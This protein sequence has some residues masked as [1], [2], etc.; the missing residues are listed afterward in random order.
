MNRENQGWKPEI[1]DLTENQLGIR[2]ACMGA[3][4]GNA[5][6]LELIKRSGIFDEEF[7]RR[8]YNDV[9][10]SGIDP[11]LHYIQF[12]FSERRLPSEKIDIRFLDKFYERGTPSIPEMVSSLASLSAYDQGQS[13]HNL[14]EGGKFRIP[15]I[16]CLI[17]GDANIRY[18]D[19]VTLVSVKDHN[20]F[21]LFTSGPDEEVP[22]EYG[23]YLD[24]YGIKYI[25]FNGEIR[26]YISGFN[27]RGRWPREMLARFAIPY[28]F[29]KMGYDYLIII[30]YDILCIRPYVLDDILELDGVVN[31]VKIHLNT[32]WF[33]PEMRAYLKNRWNFPP[34][35]FD[36]YSFGGGFLI[37]NVPEYVKSEFPLVYREIYND[38]AKFKYIRAC[39]DETA[40]GIARYHFPMDAVPFEYN[41]TPAAI[42]YDEKY[43][44]INVHYGTHHPWN[45][46]PITSNGIKKSLARYHYPLSLLLHMLDYIEYARQFDFVDR[47]FGGG[48][49]SREQIFNSIADYERIYESGQLPRNLA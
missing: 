16:A 22:A 2:E 42:P 37:F 1:L 12:G 19:I 13:A 45:L 11:L 41:R 14:S 44:T 6:L 21:D 48:I 34:A 49:P 47:V 17:L 39:D 31:A 32:N 10:E 35:N 38:L 40:L 33:P 28:E 15:K 5:E 7:Y 18:K 43:K 24:K 8:A 23:K 30:D 27:V 46:F 29:H 20:H 36:N 4:I 25:P 9:A 26:N 3:G